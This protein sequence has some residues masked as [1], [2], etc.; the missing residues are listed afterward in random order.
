MP[1][2]KRHREDSNRSPVVGASHFEGA[3]TEDVFG[4]HEDVKE[5]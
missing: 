4:A 5:S 1:Y 2:L 3:S